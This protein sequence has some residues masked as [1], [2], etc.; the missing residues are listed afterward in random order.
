MP[1]LFELIETDVIDGMLA[2]NLSPSFNWDAS[3]MTDQ[4]MRDFNDEVSVLT[5]GSA[6]S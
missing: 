6:G 4:E 5:S 3:G 2:Y 1:D